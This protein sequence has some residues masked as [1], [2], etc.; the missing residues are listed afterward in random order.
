[1]PC[2]SCSLLELLI[3]HSN[4]AHLG[5]K[6]TLLQPWLKGE[7]TEKLMFIRRNKRSAA[8]P[9]PQEKEQMDPCSFYHVKPHS[10]VWSV[11]GGRLIPGFPERE[12]RE[13][14]TGRHG[15]HICDHTPFISS[16]VFHCKFPPVDAVSLTIAAL[17]ILFSFVIL[18]HSQVCIDLFFS[19]VPNL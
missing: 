13:K 18:H 9:P 4:T 5:G 15:R 12:L 3:M 14:P 11:L 2:N 19:L 1:M 7:R 16:R 17:H 10:E 8:R 6:N